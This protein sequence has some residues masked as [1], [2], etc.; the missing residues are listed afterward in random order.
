M[1]R[2]F[3]FF[4]KDHCGLGASGDRLDQKLTSMGLT[5]I[6]TLNANSACRDRSRT[7]SCYFYAY[8]TDSGLFP[9]IVVSRPKQMNVYLNNFFV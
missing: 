1:V 7:L 5:A 2:S 8:I 4:V 9:F 6:A 3:V